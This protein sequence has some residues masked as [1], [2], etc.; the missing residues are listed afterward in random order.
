MLQS[1]FSSVRGEEAAIMQ[2]AVARKQCERSCRLCAEP[3][4]ACV[5]SPAR[6]GGYHIHI[7]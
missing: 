2:S 7:A 4:Q 5:V 1:V 6:G 3:A